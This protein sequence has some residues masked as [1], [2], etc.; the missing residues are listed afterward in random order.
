MP[1]YMFR[2]AYTSDAW[3]VQIKDPQNRMEVARTLIEAQGGKWT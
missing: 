2:E 3:A 1:T